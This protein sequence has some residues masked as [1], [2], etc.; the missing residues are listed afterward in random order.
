MPQKIL[1]TRSQWTSKEVIQANIVGEDIPG[2]P[3][4]VTMTELDDFLAA[5]LARQDEAEQ[6]LVNGDLERA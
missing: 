4:T 3:R 2:R 6:A 1:G 5:T